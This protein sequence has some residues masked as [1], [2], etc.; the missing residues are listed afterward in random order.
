MH[1]T[2]TA[3]MPYLDEI[4]KDAHP[5]AAAAEKVFDLGAR[6]FETLLM[7]S[8]TRTFY[9]G[10]INVDRDTENAGNNFF[11]LKTVCIFNERRKRVVEMDAPV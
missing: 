5:M 3:L 1:E 2:E 6:A 10:G 9:V 11:I 7:E 4:K 8:E